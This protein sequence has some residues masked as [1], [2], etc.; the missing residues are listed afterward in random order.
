MLEDKAVDADKS[1]SF[2]SQELA[3][4]MWQVYGHRIKNHLPGEVRLSLR[5]DEKGNGIMWLTEYKSN[6]ENPEVHVS[7]DRT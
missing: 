1:A 4:A 2:T 5:I 7:P 3:E 6:A